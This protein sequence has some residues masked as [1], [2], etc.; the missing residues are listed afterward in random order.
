MKKI[1]FV[2]FA[3]FAMLFTSPV[4][5]ADTLRLA[6]WFFY[7]DGNLYSPID[8]D[9]GTSP[10]AFTTVGFDLATSPQDP[11]TLGKISAQFST[12]GTYNIIGYF[13]FDIEG[14]NNPLDNEI[15]S[16]HGSAA[17]GQSWEMGLITYEFDSVENEMVP[18]ANGVT[19]DVL[20]GSLT[21][22]PDIG[23]ATP[24]GDVVMA[25]GWNLTVGADP[26]TVNYFLQTT[27][28]QNSGLYLRQEDQQASIYL[29][30]DLGGGQIPEPATWILLCSG[31][32]V[33]LLARI[34]SRR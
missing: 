31:L 13:D 28:P 19:P 26:V 4:A 1:Y 14:D 9:F 12:P 22:L 24:A 18:I 10:A 30:S 25:L 33:A 11:A 5:N 17:A 3:L 21:N 32:G 16:V 6:D 27:Q 15:G 2:V 29:S 7:I 20:A 34:R 8:N 23:G